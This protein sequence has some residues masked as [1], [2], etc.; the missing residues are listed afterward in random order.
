MLKINR[1]GKKIA[2]LKD[3]GSEPELIEVV[4]QSKITQKHIEKEEPELGLENPKEEKE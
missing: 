4:E 3:D 1:D 2:V